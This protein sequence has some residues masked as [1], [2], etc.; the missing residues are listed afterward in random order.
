ML[1]A[2]PWIPPEKPI[3]WPWMGRETMIQ[4]QSRQTR[5]E[6]SGPDR[7]HDYWGG[8][9]NEPGGLSRPPVTTIIEVL[10]VSEGLSG[11]LAGIGSLGKNKKPKIGVTFSVLQNVPILLGRFAYGRQTPRLGSRSYQ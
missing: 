5:N 9:W 3:Q 6:P 2:I 11:P 7:G 10:G 4:A 1:H 8:I